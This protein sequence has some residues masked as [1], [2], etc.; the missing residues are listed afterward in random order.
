MTNSKLKMIP[1]VIHHRHDPIELYRKES[2]YKIHLRHALYVQVVTS[3]SIIIIIIITNIII[4]N[5]TYR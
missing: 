5:N 2:Y 1:N 4:N 3:Y